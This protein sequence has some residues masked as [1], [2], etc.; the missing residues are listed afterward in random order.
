MFPGRGIGR[1]EG[2][3]D[4]LLRRTSWAM[5]RRYLAAFLGVLSLAA[6]PA[7]AQT[8]SGTVRY[9]HTDAVGSVR[10]V[11][12]ATGHVVAEHDYLPFGQEPANPSDPA[13][14]RFGAKERDGETGMSYFGARYYQTGT[15]RFTSIDP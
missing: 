3:C 5:T 6:T 11:T 2:R 8:G 1:R 7:R 10:A 14:Q 12:D 15:G 4:T 9:C 13:P